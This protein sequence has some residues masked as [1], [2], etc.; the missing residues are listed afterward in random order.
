MHDS[1]HMAKD[2]VNAKLSELRRITYI[3]FYTVS[4][5][6]KQAKLFLLQLRE[7]STKSHD[8][9]HNDGKRSKIIRRALIFHLT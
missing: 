3:L 5:K 9:W 6:K 4:Q 1:I 7:T 8:I 2:M